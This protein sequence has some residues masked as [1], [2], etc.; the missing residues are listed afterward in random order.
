MY[1]TLGFKW[2]LEV[3]CPASAFVSADSDEARNPQ[4]FIHVTVSN[5]H[6]K[7]HLKFNKMKTIVLLLCMIFSLTCFSQE[8]ELP[9][10]ESGKY[11]LK[12]IVNL[13]GKVDKLYNASLIAMTDLFKDS[14]EV[15]EYKNIEEGVIIG[16]F[17]IK[18]I[19]SGMGPKN[20]YFK[21]KIRLDFK[22]NKYKIQINN[23]GHKAIWTATVHDCSCVND[24]AENSCGVKMCISDKE[25]IT[26]KTKAHEELLIAVEN[27][28]ALIEKN[29]KTLSD[30]SDE[31]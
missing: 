20:H 7:Y 13:A 16:K 31:W 22:E 11:E 17:V 10:N 24:I 29:L 23:V 1:K 6:K 26:Q 15:I 2:L 19:H 30:K 5:K 28:K 27:L 8:K 4:R 12:E 21:F 9:Q 18:T 25:W 3:L 14:E